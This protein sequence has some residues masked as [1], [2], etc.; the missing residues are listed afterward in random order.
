MVCPNHCSVLNRQGMI[1]KIAKRVMKEKKKEE[2]K[3]K[4]EKKG[5]R[6]SKLDRKKWA[7]KTRREG[8]KK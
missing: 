3:R 6:R 4:K 7:G 1:K 8:E 2:K 5:E